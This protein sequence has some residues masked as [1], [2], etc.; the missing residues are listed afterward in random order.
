V[1]G[2]ASGREV[3]PFLRRH[4][5]GLSEEEIALFV[6]TFRRQIGSDAFFSR[7]C[8]GCHGR[9]YDFARL[10]LIERDGRL[11]GRYSGRDIAGFLPGHARMTGD[12]AARVLE[13]LTALRAGTR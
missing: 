9:A 7:R 3:A 2:A 4:G 12:E 10:R 6:A 8:S 13:A 11:V 5:G 1:R